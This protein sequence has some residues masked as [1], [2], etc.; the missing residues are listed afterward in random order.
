[1]RRRAHGHNDRPVPRA[2]EG[3]LVVQHTAAT[4]R[5]VGDNGVM[6]PTHQTIVR[7]DVLIHS[8]QCVALNRSSS[9]RLPC[10]P[11]SCSGAS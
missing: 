5:D 9:T 3:K 11:S 8:E 4:L 7:Q 2:L 6:S 1:M 10:G